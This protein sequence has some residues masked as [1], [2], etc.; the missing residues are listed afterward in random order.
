[1]IQNFCMLR[2]ILDYKISGIIIKQQSCQMRYGQIIDPA[3]VSTVPVY[4]RVQPL[5]DIF[6]MP[7]QDLQQGGSV[8]RISH[9]YASIIT[10][11]WAVI[12]GGVIYRAL[13]DAYV[14]N[15]AP[16]KRQTS[17]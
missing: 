5:Q 16:T 6:G 15:H 3:D 2:G 9:W 17:I 7:C 4:R 11:S 14:I 1:M 8:M 13:I 10:E 12:C